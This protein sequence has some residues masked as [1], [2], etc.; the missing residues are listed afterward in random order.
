MGGTP[1]A[2]HG[3]TG[4]GVSDMI[5]LHDRHINIYLTS[6]IVGGEGGWFHAYPQINS[7]VEFVCIV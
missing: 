3:G 6:E 1:A 5:T 7:G 2:L 4:G